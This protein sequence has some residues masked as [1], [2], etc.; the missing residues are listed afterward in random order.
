MSDNVWESC[1]TIHISLPDKHVLAIS[2]IAAQKG[3]SKS[4]AAQMV[5][6]ESSTL[7]DV[8]DSLTKEGFFDVTG[9]LYDDVK[10]KCEAMKKC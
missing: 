7:N 3:I 6:L 5:M 1:S 10:K 8:L 9:S 2:A 4:K